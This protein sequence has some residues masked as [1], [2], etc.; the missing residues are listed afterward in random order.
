[1]GDVQPFNSLTSGINAMQL[2]KLSPLAG[3]ILTG[4]LSACGGGGG[5]AP[6]PAAPPPPPAITVSALSLNS[7]TPNTIAENTLRFDGGVCSGGTG[8]LTAAW[9][10]GDST[11][12]GSY[13]PHNYLDSAAGT[14]TVTVTC[15]DT[16]GTTAGTATLRLTVLAAAMNGFL[17]KSWTTYRA[18]ETNASPYPVAGI[19][20][21]GDLY[22]VWIRRYNTIDKAVAAGLA[23]LSSP[24]WTVTNTGES[25]TGGSPDVLYTGANQS[26]YDDSNGTLG[27]NG[28][29]API[30]MAVSSNGHAIAAWMAGSSLYFSTKSSLHDPWTVAKE[31]TTP[32]IN[33]SVKVVVNDDGNGAIAYCTNAGAM[34]VPITGITEG[35]A[36]SISTQ[37]GV[38][39]TGIAGLQLYQRFRAFDVAINTQSKIYAVG[40]LSGSTSGSSV[41]VQT[42][43]PGSPGVWSTPVIRV[44]DNLATPPSSL[45]MSLSP[46]GQKGMIAW[47]QIPTGNPNFAVHTAGLQA[48]GIN[49]S[50]GKV[51]NFNY[52]PSNTYVRPM[53]AVNDGGDV[54]LTMLETPSGGAQRLVI[55]NCAACAV[56]SLQGWATNL[57]PVYSVT[58][59]GALPSLAKQYVAADLAIDQWGTALITSGDENFGYSWA[60]TYSKNGVFSNLKRI[61][62]TDT[63]NSIDY[64]GT[65]SFRYQTMRATPDGNAILTTAIYDNSSPNPIKSG[66]MLLK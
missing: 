65:S 46:S 5:D 45:S 36:K 63:L 22:G 62:P 6:P 7:A 16:A 24:N 28:E 8:T 35:T 48:D 60:G 17:G 1:M 2:K 21:A 52:T 37:C 40:V 13:A 12:V 19:T 31:I 26:P 11:T 49:W 30:D 51:I 42:Y 10:F 44:A 9:D 32:I 3:L 38:T 47:P 27:S 66:F 25:P 18:L 20:S 29:T 14:R 43:S 54:A 58:S 55:T 57:T 34:V 59:T 23:S 64:Y 39:D 56:T 50:S 41:A 61:G 15:T 33:S 53:I 4:L